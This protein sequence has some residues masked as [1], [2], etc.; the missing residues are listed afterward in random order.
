MDTGADVYVCPA[1][2]NFQSAPISFLFAADNSRIAV[3]GSRLLR[4]CFSGINYSHHFQVAKVTTPILGAD[5]LA[6]HG[7]VVDVRGQRLIHVS[8]R[9]STPL[10]GSSH[11]SG[12]QYLR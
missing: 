1:G 3:Y 8:T 2:D 9:T 10:F 6:V 12:I 4:L 7:L 11:I 5:F